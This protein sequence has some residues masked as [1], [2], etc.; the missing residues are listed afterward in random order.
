MGRAV[1]S[2]GEGGQERSVQQQRDWRERGGHAP[3]V[4]PGGTAGNAD[5]DK[6]RNRP[7]AEGQHRHRTRQRPAGRARSVMRQDLAL[8]IGY[9]MLMVLLAVAG[10]VTPWLAAAMSGSS[11]LV[12]LNSLRA[13]SR[14]VSWQLSCICWP[15]ACCWAE[16]VSRYFCGRCAPASSRTWMARRTV[17]NMTM[18]RG[19]G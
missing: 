9:N 14:G 6:R 13:R 11:L 3:E 7:Q 12:M 16:P 8:C 10:F 4:V 15:R 2:H 18:T 19:S 5:K 1:R 17:C